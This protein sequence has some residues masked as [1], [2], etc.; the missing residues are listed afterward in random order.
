MTYFSYSNIIKVGINIELTKKIGSAVKSMGVKIAQHGITG[1]PLPLIARDF[2]KQ[3]LGKG[4]V[5]TN[6]MLVA[7]DVLEVFEPELYAP[8][9]NWTINKFGKEGVPEKE[10]F[11]KDSKMGIIEHFDQIYA[12]KEDSVHAMTYA[13]YTSA[14]TFFKAFNSYGM[15]KYLQ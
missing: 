11:L 8:I 5:G 9:K 1:T 7:W 15:I 3:V 2:P 13:A 4:N 6:W 14:I 12:M 10:T